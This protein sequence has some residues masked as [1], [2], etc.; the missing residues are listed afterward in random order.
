[1]LAPLTR[2]AL[3]FLLHHRV[4]G[5]AIA[6]GA[7]MCEMAL[8]AG[9]VRRFHRADV[10]RCRQTY[11]CCCWRDVACHAWQGQRCCT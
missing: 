5:R 7:A 3:G 2:A 10:N 1:M 11:A 9:Q 4:R 8:A 6:P